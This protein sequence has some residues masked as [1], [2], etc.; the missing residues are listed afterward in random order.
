[1]LLLMMILRMVWP[2]DSLIQ[3][4]CEQSLCMHWPQYPERASLLNPHRLLFN[5]PNTTNL[6]LSEPT[7]PSPMSPPYSQTRSPLRSPYWCI[8]I[9]VSPLPGGYWTPSSTEKGQKNTPMCPPCS[10]GKKGRCFGGLPCDRCKEKVYSR[11]RCEGRMAFRFSPRK[12][13]VTVGKRRDG[14]GM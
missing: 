4:R 1:M 9:T 13:A 7:S 11:E 5:K 3:Q 10:S 6:P 2:R 8:V 14:D 12:R